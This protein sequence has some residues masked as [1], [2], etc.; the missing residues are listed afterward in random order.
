MRMEVEEGYRGGVRGKMSSCKMRAKRYMDTNTSIMANIYQY[1]ITLSIYEASVH[2]STGRV[3][4]VNKCT[5]VSR[6]IITLTDDIVENLHLASKLVKQ[7][8]NNSTC[9]FT[10]NNFTLN[11]P[12]LTVFFNVRF[13]KLFN[14]YA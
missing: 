2:D 4:D 5:R 10:I 6:C 13:L 7:A 8:N 3:W 1:S 14:E 9:M 12:T 11:K